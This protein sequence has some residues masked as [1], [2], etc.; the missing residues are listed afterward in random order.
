MYI[1]EDAEGKVVV[2][3]T[4]MKDVVWLIVKQNVRF[5]MQGVL[6]LYITCQDL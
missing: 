1:K 5:Q 6:L 3:P 4:V 2:I